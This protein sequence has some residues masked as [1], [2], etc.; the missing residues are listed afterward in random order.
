MKKILISYQR[1]FRVGIRCMTLRQC[2]V[3]NCWILIKSH[4]FWKNFSFNFQRFAFKVFSNQF[5]RIKLPTAIKSF[6]FSTLK[7]SSP[8]KTKNI[9]HSIFLL[10]NFDFVYFSLCQQKEKLERKLKIIGNILL[11]VTLQLDDRL[12]GIF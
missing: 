3:K 1:P 5:S 4:F 10:I 6:S 12:N 2:H 11:Q 9:C 8:H 7:V